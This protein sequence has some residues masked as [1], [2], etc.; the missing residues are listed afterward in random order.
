LDINSL[1]ESARNGD[2]KSE[3]DLFKL[4]T[5]RFR[6]L[7]TLRLRDSDA[8]EEAVQ[9]A[10]MVISKEYREID[11]TVSFAAWAQKVLDNRLANYSRSRK[12]KEKIFVGEANPD[13]SSS[14]NSSNPGSDLKR[15]LLK[16]LREISGS[17]PRYA[18]ILN[19]HY[20]GYGTE[21]ICRK[22]EISS[23]NFYAILSRAR[24][25]LK[26]CLRKGSVDN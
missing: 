21:E 20:Q 22:L 7:A 6:Y 23:T 10:L 15:K 2:R 25:L 11:I 8:A 14:N 17:N 12:R 3:Q 18:R 4:L 13:L 26:I 24:S 5:V 19:Y 1:H 9:E 16:C